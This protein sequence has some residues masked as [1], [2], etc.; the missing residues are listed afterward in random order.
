MAAAPPNDFDYD[1]YNGL[2]Q[3]PVPQES[4]GWVGVPNYDASNAKGTYFLAA[5]SL[6]ID[7]ATPLAGFNQSFV[8]AGPDVG[9]YETGGPPLVFGV[10]DSIDLSRAVQTTSSRETKGCGCHLVGRTPGPGLLWVFTWIV[11]STLRLRE[12]RT[13]R[14]GAE[15]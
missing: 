1:L 6:G 2:I 11:L 10:D 9:A 13:R 14:A 8:G 3:S 7:S 5:G 15:K 4:H 12:P